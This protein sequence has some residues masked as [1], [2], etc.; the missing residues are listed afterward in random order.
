MYYKINVEKTVLIIVD[1]QEKLM[2]VMPRRDRVVKNTLMLMELARLFKIPIIVTEQYPQGL[3]S[4]LPELQ[5]AMSDARLLE[6]TTFSM[7]NQLMEIMK[8]MKRTQ[9]ILVGSETHVCVFQTVRDLLR[10]GYEVQVPCDAVCSRSEMHYENG[11]SLMRESGAAV[12]NSETVVFDVLGKAGTE[13]F[14]IMQ[15]LIKHA[16]EG[17]ISWQSRS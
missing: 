9:V 5:A 11:L 8:E 14:K 2:K 16:L 3:G 4:T 15:P 17:E 12:T 6:K 1:L 7:G 13:E 10:A